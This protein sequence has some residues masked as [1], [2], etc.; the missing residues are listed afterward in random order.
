MFEPLSVVIKGR[1]RLE[2]A[3]AIA[4]NFL[5]SRVH[6]VYIYEREK[7]ANFSVLRLVKLQS[8]FSPGL[9]SSVMEELMSAAGAAGFQSKSPRLTG[10]DDSGGG[11]L[12]LIKVFETVGGRLG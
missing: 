4:H 6:V 5:A 7:H 8:I 2:A 12:T 11:V 3:V 10:A 1:P 9:A